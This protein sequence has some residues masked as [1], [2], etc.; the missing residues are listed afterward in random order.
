MSKK[1]VVIA[2]SSPGKVYDLLPLELKNEIEVILK[3][4]YTDLVDLLSQE[5]CSLLVI[6]SFNDGNISSEK[7][8]EIVSLAPKTP[9]VVVTSGKSAGNGRSDFEDRGVLEIVAEEDLPGSISGIIEKYIYSGYGMLRKWPLEELF[10]YCFPIITTIDY[11]PLCQTITDYFK[12]MFMAEA[13][14]LI[15]KQDGRGSGFKLLSLTGINDVKGLVE[16]LAERGGGC[17]EGCTDKGMVSTLGQFLGGEPPPEILINF[18]SVFSIRFELEGMHPV[19][20]FMFMKAPP[21]EEVLEAELIQFVVRQVRFALFNAE[22]GIKVQSLI[23]IDDLTKLYN[24][25]YLKVVLDRELKRSERYDMPVSLLF[26][27][28]DYFKR[29]NDSFGHLVGSRVLWEFGTILNM[30]VRETDTVI[31]YGGDEF[32]VILV[33]TNPEH[34]LIAAERMRVSVEEHV[35][36]KEEDLNLKLTVSIGIATYPTHAKEKKQLLEM[37]DKAMYRGKDTTRNVVYVADS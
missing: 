7:V 25:R 14:F 33:E 8:S 1:R 37:A 17:I 26:L 28:I 29:V 32:V 6:S 12:E 16:F 11:D 18:N 31:R 36:M 3:D 35:F 19:Y 24:S 23:Y 27:D 22:K 2:S 20:C 4:D 13:G 9:L 10:D 21:Y 15:T 34:G 5:V 30:C